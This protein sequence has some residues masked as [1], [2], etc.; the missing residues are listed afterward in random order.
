MDRAT[1]SRL[2][3]PAVLVNN[4]GIGA[5]KP[6]LE[7]PVGDFDRV[8][9][10]NLRGAFLCSQ[11]MARHMVHH[12]CAGSIINIA[13]TR[14]FMSEPNTEAY[15]ASKG[16]IVALTH[17]TA[18]SLSPHRI[19]VNCICPGWIEV[20]DWQFSQRAEIPHHS[21]RDREQHPAGRVGTPEDIAEACLYFAEHAGFVTGQHLVIDGGM[22]VKMIYE[23]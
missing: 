1:V 2:G 20:R 13:S 16:G 23:E 11:T 4:A 14:A 8:L 7:L 10:V 6:F 5:T 17:A 21:K 15:A 18:M 9:A 12:K 3:C 19:R 22:S